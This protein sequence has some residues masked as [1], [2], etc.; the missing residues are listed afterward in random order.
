MQK[1]AECH[2]CNTILPI[3]EFQKHKNYK[4]GYSKKCKKCRS[5]WAKQYYQK[6][7][8]A[9][10]LKSKNRYVPRLRKVRVKLSI[11]EQRLK[12]SQRN[13]QQRLRAAKLRAIDSDRLAI[14]KQKTSESMKRQ[15]ALYPN[16]FKARRKVSNAIRDGR[17]KKVLECQICGKPNPQAHHSDYSKPLELLWLCK[18]HHIAW[19]RCFIAIENET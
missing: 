19:H 15:R 18:E 8:K 11:E 12:V 9:I 16:K 14:H 1:E 13:K 7:C 17:L 4:S 5:I 10:K 2:S 6:N 3:S